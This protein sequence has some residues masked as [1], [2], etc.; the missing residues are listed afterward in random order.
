MKTQIFLNN[1]GTEANDPIV[2]GLK[3][4]FSVQTDINLKSIVGYIGST[5]PPTSQFSFTK[6]ENNFYQHSL[7]AGEGLSIVGKNYLRIELT[8]FSNHKTKLEY[9][10]YVAELP[11]DYLEVINL[12]REWEYYSEGILVPPQMP[13]RLLNTWSNSRRIKNYGGISYLEVYQ[14]DQFFGNVKALPVTELKDICYI[15]MRKKLLATEEI[16]LFNI[17]FL[18][19]DETIAFTKQYSVKTPPC[20]PRIFTDPVTEE[21]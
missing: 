21:E 11:E 7:I 8:S 9:Q 15:Y 20:L 17:D 5:T 19:A 18:N 14:P 4:N 12:E 6:K 3:L 2:K 13:I 1:A 10:I 16:H